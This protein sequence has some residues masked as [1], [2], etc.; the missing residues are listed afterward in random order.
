MLLSLIYQILIRYAQ[1]VGPCGDGAFEPVDHITRVAISIYSVTEFKARIK[2][3]RASLQANS[4]EC[5][6]DALQFEI[7]FVEKVVD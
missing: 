5:I 4:S 3:T 7:H 2:S 1:G 6:P